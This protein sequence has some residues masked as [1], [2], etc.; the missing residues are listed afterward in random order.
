MIPLFDSEII[1]AD[2]EILK[3][4]VEYIQNNKDGK[5]YLEL[6]ND[7]HAFF[8]VMLHH[9]ENIFDTCAPFTR[10]SQSYLFGIKLL[11]QLIREIGLYTP[12]QISSWSN[13]ISFRN[14]T[15]ELIISKD[16]KRLY[17][18]LKIS[19]PINLPCVD[20]KKEYPFVQTNEV[21]EGVTPQPAKEA[22]NNKTYSIHSTTDKYS[23]FSCLFEL[24]CLPARRQLLSLLTGSSVSQ[25]T[26]GSVC[27]HGSMTQKTTE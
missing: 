12:I 24:R 11:E 17:E 1:Q 22:I 2:P 15:K 3:Q 9:Q 19:S 16:V 25:S 10:N 21:D 4:S 26:S 23:L 8:E 27:F 13:C 14:E 20:C 18:L 7:Y 6:F 5:D